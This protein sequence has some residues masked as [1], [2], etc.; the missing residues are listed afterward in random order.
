[1]NTN[2]GRGIFAVVGLIA[3][4]AATIYLVKRADDNETLAENLNTWIHEQADHNWVPEAEESTAVYDDQSNEYV[5]ETIETLLTEELRNENAVTVGEI[6]NNEVVAEIVDEKRI[7]IGDGEEEI[8]RTSKEYR[9]LINDAYGKAISGEEPIL[10]LYG[11]TNGLGARGEALE[12]TPEGL[13][14]RVYQAEDI[15]KL[16]TRMLN[17]K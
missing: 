1:M 9:E 6:R 14:G 4:A 5:D 15:I 11:K 17:S 3:A 7:V 2:L 16:R 13:K 10:V 8:S 12:E